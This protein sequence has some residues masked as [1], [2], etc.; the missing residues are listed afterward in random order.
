[1]RVLDTIPHPHCKITI[2]YMNEKYVLKFEI[3]QYEQTYKFD[4]EDVGSIEALK[5]KVT[6][7]F[8]DEVIAIFYTMR[9]LIISFEK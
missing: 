3:G 4:V 6:S 7:D 9:S 1:M 8:V 2:F 5:Q